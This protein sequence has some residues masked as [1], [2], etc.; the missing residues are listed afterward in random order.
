MTNYQK[1][2]QIVGECKDKIEDCGFTLPYIQYELGDAKRRLGQCNYKNGR[3]TINISKCYFEKYI[4]TGEI[5][6]IEDTILHEMCHALPNGMNHKAQWQF[7]ANKV[8]RM[9]GYNIK[10]LAET[11]ETI[12]EVKIE[13]AKYTIVCQNCGHTYYYQRM[14]NKL[15]N[16]SNCHCGKCKGKLALV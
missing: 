9:F 10:R 3:Y 12:K 13:N 5:D 6:K 4:A 8:N 11:D 7:Y 16:L 2:M 1:F 15:K 14:T